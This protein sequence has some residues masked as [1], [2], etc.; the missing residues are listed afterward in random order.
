[1]DSL[2][3]FVQVIAAILFGGVCLVTVIVFLGA[4]FN[5]KFTF[6]TDKG[7]IWSR[8]KSLKI[9]GSTILV[10]MVLFFWT[11]PA[12]WFGGSSPEDNF[13][14]A[15]S[16]E[17]VLEKDLSFPGRKRIRQ[18]I[19]APKAKTADERAHTVM[20]AAIELQTQKDADLAM[21]MLVPDKD[22]IDAGVNMAL[23]DYSPDGGGVSG[24]DGWTWEVETSDFN[25]THRHMEI[26]KLYY[27]HRGEFRT[28]DGLT[29]NEKLADFIAEKL[30][31]KPEETHLPFI[32]MEEYLTE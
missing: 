15:K 20:K 22:I 8:K 32:I 9:F 6:E 10:S 23:A 30:G 14:H 12:S 29:D 16:Y 19:V 3:W 28:P 2:I 7:E 11:A 24:E 13:S 17:V 27:N 21:I 1:M 4:V 25:F 18:H 5:P 26:G 31:I